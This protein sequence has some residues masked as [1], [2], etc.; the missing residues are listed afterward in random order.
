M[1]AFRTLWIALL[2]LSAFSQ[3]TA[4]SYPRDYFRAPLDIPLFLSGSFGELRSNHFH[5]GLDFKTQQKEG[6]PVM[7]AADGYISRIKISPFGYGKAIYIDHPNGYTTVYGHLQKGYEAIEAY[8]RKQQYKQENFEIEVFPEPGELTVKKGDTIGLSGNT[9]GSAGPHLHFEIRDTKSE[10]IIN[11]MFFGFDKWVADARKPVLSGL[12]A[13][14]IGS[15]AGVNGSQRPIM[16]NLKLLEDGTYLADA[17]EASGRIAF[18]VSAYDQSDGNYTKHGIYRIQTFVNGAPGFGYELDTFAFDES[19]YVNALLDYPRFRKTG[20]RL[21]KLFWEQPYSLSLIEPGPEAGIVTVQPNLAKMYRIEIADFNGNVINVTIPIEYTPKAASIAPEPVK[22]TP[23]FL[24]ASIDNVYRKDNV[25]VSIPA[26]TFY[27]DFYL[28]FSVESGR[29]HLHDDSVP[30]HR[31]FTISI[32][33]NN[34]PETARKQTFIATIDGGKPNY[35]ATKWANG[36][37]TAQTKDLGDFA[38]LRDTVAP[39]IKPLNFK[40]AKW[41][42]KNKTLAVKIQ[43]DLSGIQSYSGYLNGKW[44]L[45][46]YDYKSRTLTYDFSDGHTL[47]GRNELRMVVTDNVGNSAI[48]ETWFFRALTP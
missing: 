7:A 18:A 21:Q 28:D 32:T 43:D 22:V 2:S 41:I 30:V 34:V 33:D 36:A 29:L 24:K 3:S 48:F 1:D 16:L 4:P 40:E 14:P 37:F 12:M 47:E 8:I 46:E 11:P 35:N 31:N 9:G 39:S 15:D 26:G 5:A 10:K 44:V 6:F 13:Y 25:T 45:F 17:I 42:S 23:Y 19:R 20:M 27:N 38:L